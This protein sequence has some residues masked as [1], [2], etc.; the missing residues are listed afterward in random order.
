MATNWD[1]TKELTNEPVWASSQSLLT[2]QL[3]SQPAILAYH[4]KCTVYELPPSFVLNVNH[5]Q[6]KPSYAE[7]SS[8]Y[9]FYDYITAPSTTEGG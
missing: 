9:F 5:N 1:R 4:T 7:F 6:T 8:I 3:A 2:I